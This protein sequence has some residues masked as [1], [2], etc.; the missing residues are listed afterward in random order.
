MP[1]FFLHIRDGVSFISDPDGSCLPDIPRR[2]ALESARE[3][4]IQSIIG[5]TPRHRSTL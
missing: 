4:I 1:L 3:L 2:Q 5:R